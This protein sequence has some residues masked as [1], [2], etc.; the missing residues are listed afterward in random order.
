MNFKRLNFRQ[1]S[2]YLFPLMLEHLKFY[3]MTFILGE[4]KY[5]EGPKNSKS[6]PGNRNRYS[7]CHAQEKEAH[8]CFLPDFI[9]YTVW[10]CES[11]WQISFIFMERI[12]SCFQVISYYVMLNHMP[13]KGVAILSYRMLSTI[14][15]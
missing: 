7:L 2:N 8:G 13:I 12:H 3:E 4:K 1:E 10:R 11:S 14:I 5:F 6:E 9:K 15:N